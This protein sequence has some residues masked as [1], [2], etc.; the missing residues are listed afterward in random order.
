MGEGQEGQESHRSHMELQSHIESLKRALPPLL[1]SRHAEVTQAA[2]GRIARELT[3]K[4]D[5]MGALGVLDLDSPSG[6]L[7]VQALRNSGAVVRKAIKVLLGGGVDMEMSVALT[8]LAVIYS[9]D[10][11]AETEA[12][13]REAEGEGQE[14]QG[15][16]AG[17]VAVVAVPSHKHSTSTTSMHSMHTVEVDNGN[18]ENAVCGENVGAHNACIQFALEV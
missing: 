3:H 8:R 7:L 10:V 16:G 11:E 9:D 15:V 1:A 4:G 13:G 5:S 18:V 14:G 17:A 12:Q 6:S 2:V